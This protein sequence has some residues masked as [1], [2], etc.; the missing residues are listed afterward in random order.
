VKLEVIFQMIFILA[1]KVT[2]QTE[3]CQAELS[4]GIELSPFTGMPPVVQTEL[5]QAEL[6]EAYIFPNVNTTG[7]VPVK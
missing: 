4:K 1:L 5:C 6:A 3:S 2:R 7:W